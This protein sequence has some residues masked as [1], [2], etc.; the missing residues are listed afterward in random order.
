VYVCAILPAVNQLDTPREDLSERELALAVEESLHD[1]FR[2]MAQLPGA[3]LEE[4]DDYSRHLA[5]PPNPMFKGVWGTRLVADDVHAAAEEVLAWYR[6]RDAP[7]VF[8]WSGP[9]TEPRDLGARLEPH[10]FAPFELDAQGQVAE[11]RSLDW[12]ALA[13]APGALRVERVVDDAGLETF[14]RTFVEAFGVPEWAGAAWVDATRSFGVGRAPWDLYVGRLDG[15]PVATSMLFCGAGVATAFGVGA[16]EEARGQGIGAA[17]TLA[18][19]ADARDAGYRYAVLFATELGAP[20][21]RRIGFRD[22]DATI[23]RWIWFAEA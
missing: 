1:L 18:G 14:G 11:L 4:R 2:A 8:W 17:V 22:A 15:R 6:E 3:E 23:S 20:V 16:L 12:G 21:Y 5:F 9:T 7:F 19:L 10:G 13:R